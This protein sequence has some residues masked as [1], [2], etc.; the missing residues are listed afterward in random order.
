MLSK[1]QG[2]SKKRRELLCKFIKGELQIEPIAAC[3]IKAYLSKR[4]GSYFCNG[5]FQGQHPY[6]DN[7]DYTYDPAKNGENIIKHGISFNEVYSYSPNFGTMLVPVPDKTDVARYVMFCD[8]DIAS[9]TNKLVM[10]PC[11]IE[12]R[13]M[14]YVIC[15]IDCSS[16]KLR[17]ISARFLSEKRRKYERTI[18]QTL[19]RLDIKKKEK[20]D[21]ILHCLDFFERNLINQRR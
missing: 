7:D 21:F 9:D 5:H 14:A 16:G 11:S 8:L 1:M 2:L 15:I 17:F 12:N 18:E 10:P 19:E 6:A 13:K 3:D 4:L 20:K